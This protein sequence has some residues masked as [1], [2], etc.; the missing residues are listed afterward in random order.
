MSLSI[1]W[2]PASFNPS[3]RITAQWM[4]W[5]IM[6]RALNRLPTANAGA[7]LG[8]VML[9]ATFQCVV[10]PVEPRTVNREFTRIAKAAGVTATPHTLRHTA[11]TSLLNAG[12]PVAVVA[13]QLGEDR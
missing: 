10:P 11:A 7:V 6:S 12:H 3:A 4:S 1:T 13:E 2:L 8:C 9:G 5:W